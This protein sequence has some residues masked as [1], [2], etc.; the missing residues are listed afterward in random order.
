MR[1]LLTI[2]FVLTGLCASAQTVQVVYTYDAAGSRIKR[3]FVEGSV[4]LRSSLM[5][6]DSVDVNDLSEDLNKQDFMVYPNPTY[7]N[8]VLMI[9]ELPEDPTKAVLRLYDANGRLLLKQKGVQQHNYFDLGAYE[10]GNYILLYRYKRD[11]LKWKIIK[12]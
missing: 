2:L 3:E 8:V 6:I 1:S 9:P 11:R 10:S 7:G 12:I 4:E 5:T